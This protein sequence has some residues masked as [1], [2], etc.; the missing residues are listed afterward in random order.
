[1]DSG[2]T[3]MTIE[4]WDQ[5]IAADPSLID[6]YPGVAFLAEMKRWQDGGTPRLDIIERIDNLKPKGEV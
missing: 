1:M 6:R 3:L 4:E 5:E 2:G